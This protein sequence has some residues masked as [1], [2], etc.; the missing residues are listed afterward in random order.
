MVI[1]LKILS[2]VI[3]SDNLF[4]DNPGRNIG[5]SSCRCGSCS[6]GTYQTFISWWAIVFNVELTPH[7]VPTILLSMRN[8]DGVLAG[9]PL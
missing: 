1:P 2:V 8:E 5:E 3:T 6:M 4:L 9:L 7:A